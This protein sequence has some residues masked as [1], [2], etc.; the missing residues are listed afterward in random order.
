MTDDE[1]RQLSALA[2]DLPA[3]SLDARRAEQI[4]RGARGQLG[5]ARSPVR[6][7]EPA[8]AAALVASYLVWAI[9]RV[10]EALR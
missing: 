4:A 7:L 10:I 5:R 6:W 3:I 1:T 9:A 8:I 2:R